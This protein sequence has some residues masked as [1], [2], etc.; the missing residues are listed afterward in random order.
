M[1]QLIRVCFFWGGWFSFP[2]SPVGV[3]E[4]GA[5]GGVGDGGVGGGQ[6]EDPE[7]AHQDVAS[8]CTMTSFIH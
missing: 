4:E 6:P 2:L 7:T 3:P 1:F 5:D 8:C